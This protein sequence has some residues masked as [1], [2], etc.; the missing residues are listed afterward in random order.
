ML[1]SL[2]SL[3]RRSGVRKA[4]G[5]LAALIVYECVRAKL[6]SAAAAERRAAREL[7]IA[8]ADRASAARLETLNAAVVAAGEATLKADAEYAAARV[9]RAR[10]RRGAGL[11]LPVSAQALDEHATALG[12]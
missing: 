12:V 1:R 5:L 8:I 9:A 3:M 10:V 7:K 6:A 4:L 11:A 2:L